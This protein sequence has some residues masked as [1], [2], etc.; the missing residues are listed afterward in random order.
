MEVFKFDNSPVAIDYLCI[1]YAKPQLD[2]DI[3][4]TDLCAFTFKY[5]S[6][7]AFTFKYDSH[8]IFCTKDVFA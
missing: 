8:A 3:I 5:D 7:C 4:V 2:S 6:L 1:Q